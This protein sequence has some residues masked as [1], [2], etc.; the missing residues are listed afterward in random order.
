MKTGLLLRKRFCVSFLNDKNIANPPSPSHFVF[1]SESCF[2]HSGSATIKPQNTILY[3]QNTESLSH[4]SLSHF[5]FFS[6]SCFHHSGSTT[7]IVGKRFF[8]Y[9]NGSFTK[10]KTFL[11]LVPRRQKVQEDQGTSNLLSSFVRLCSAL[12]SL[13]VHNKKIT[14]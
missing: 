9:E 7:I 2:H 5:V 4:P 11:C 13:P 3:P 10:R 8:Y 6:E 1:F 12:R 14:N